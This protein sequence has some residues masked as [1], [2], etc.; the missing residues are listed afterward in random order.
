M[1]GY[2]SGSS[3]CYYLD[4]CVSGGNAE[5]TAAT[6]AQMKSSATYTGDDWNFATI[7]R[8]DAAINDGYPI[9]RGSSLDS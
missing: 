4:S 6:A 3:D 9:L 7:W 2:G 5:G 8:I 1:L